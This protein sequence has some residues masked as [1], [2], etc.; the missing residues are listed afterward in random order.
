MVDAM[1]GVAPARTALIERFLAAQGWLDAERGLLAGDASF[2]RYYRLR[3]GTESAVLMD[4]P[5]P[6]EDVRPFVAVATHLVRLGYSAPRILGA[7]VESGL[8][9]LEDL[10][11]ET[12]TRRL[13]AGDDERRLY[14]LAVDLLIDLHRRPGAAGIALPAY[15][16]ER[17]LAEATLLT[18]W[19][20]PA[21]SGGDTD[22][23]IRA[24][25][26]AGWREVLAAA[27]SGPQT[28]VLRDYHVDNLMW[29]PERDGLAR[30]GLLDF[31]DA[32]LGPAAYDL[33]SLIED[34]RRDVDEKLGQDLIARYLAAFPAL[35]PERFAAAYAVLGGQRNAKIIG[36][37]TRL[38]RR[39]GKPQYLAHIPRV[40]RWLERDLTHP[41]LEPLRAWFDR[42]LPPQRR[43]V[44]APKAST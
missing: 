31:Q 35:D 25:Y 4:A 39:D 24:D 37:F 42:H 33:V 9:L 21:L 7:D 1:G 30:I 12:Y 10:G 18:D 22:P 23:A 6:Q 41:A 34:A 17:Y 27:V 3:R 19:Y 29:L 11:D 40:W 14:E 44:P 2:R 8:L 26:V 28:L 13:A 32:V 43:Q 15:D 36:I 38:C 20:L 16:E 5:P